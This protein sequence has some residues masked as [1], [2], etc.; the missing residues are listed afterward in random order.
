MGHREA[1]QKG[2]EAQQ[3]PGRGPRTGVCWCP[4]SPL[5]SP[6]ILCYTSTD[7]DNAEQHI[8]ML[9]A[10]TAV[11]LSPHIRAVCVLMDGV[12]PFTPSY[13]TDK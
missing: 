4:S 1:P 13:I 9:P 10:V 11:C 5:L 3:T 6:S 12:G 2:A 7:N 8:S